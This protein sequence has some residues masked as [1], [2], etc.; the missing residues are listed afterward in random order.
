MLVVIVEDESDVAEFTKLFI[1]EIEEVTDIQVF[2]SAVAA[3]KDTRWISKATVLLTDYQMPGINGGE[4]AETVKAVNPS[5]YVILA[6]AFPERE[7]G[8]D[9]I[10]N[11][12]F[13]VVLMKPYSKADLLYA[14]RFGLE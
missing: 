1:E 14:V 7:F 3:L 10:F 11:E 6:T 8:R 2:S 12:Y 4:L 13:D 5:V 9:S